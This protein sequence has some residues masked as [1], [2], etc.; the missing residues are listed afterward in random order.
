MATKAEITALINAIATGELNTALEVRTFAEALNTSGFNLQDNDTE[1]ILYD[2]A[3]AQTL[4][5]RLTAIETSINN[6]PVI[7]AQGRVL[8]LNV[9]QS[10]GSIS[11]SGDFSSGT[12][13]ADQDS[14][15][16]ITITFDNVLSTSN[17]QPVLTTLSRSGSWTADNEVLLACRSLTTSSMQLIAKEFGSNTQNVDILIT[18]F[19]T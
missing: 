16:L 4:R 19:E 2:N 14:A 3:G 13:V 8:G 5:E 6:I 1:N 17:Y 11:V 15:N 12:V 7:L 18:L 9:G 10:T